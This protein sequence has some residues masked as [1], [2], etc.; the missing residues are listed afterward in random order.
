MPPLILSFFISFSPPSVPSLPNVRYSSQPLQL[1]ALGFDFLFERGSWRSCCHISNYPPSQVFLTLSHLFMFLGTVKYKNMF[2]KRSARYHHTLYD[3][4][5]TNYRLVWKMATIRLPPPCEEILF[6]S[7][8][9]HPSFIPFSSRPSSL[10]LSPPALSSS[11]LL[12]S[13]IYFAHGLLNLLSHPQLLFLPLL[14][15]LSTLPSI[16]VFLDATRQHMQQ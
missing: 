16:S 8:V 13:Y 10:N 6:I 12:P 1:P 9:L 4:H 11:G 14:L 3:E 5:A 15:L 7:L 2:E